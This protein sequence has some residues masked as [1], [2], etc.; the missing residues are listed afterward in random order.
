[1]S[2]LAFD[3]GGTHMRIALSEKGMLGHVL[4]IATPQN[5]KDAVRTIQD[6]ATGKTVEDIVGGIAGIIADGTVIDSPN[7]PSWNGFKMERSLAETFGVPVRIYNDAELAGIGEA[8]KGAGL[9]YARVGYV[10]IG[11]GVG[12]ALVVNDDAGLRTDAS[13][14]GRLIVEDGRTLESFIG[15]AALFIEFGDRPEYLPQSVYDERTRLLAEGLRTLL[16]LWEPDIFIL[17]GPLVYGTPAFRIEAII[18]EL[19]G[20]VPVVLAEHKD[21]SGLRGAALVEMR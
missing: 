11:T 13:E 3:I 5:P 6:F 9:G 7:L 18:E 20:T 8:M 16:A 4:T 15:G 12:G 17:N 21:Q 1:M 10:T 14:P 2:R 19:T